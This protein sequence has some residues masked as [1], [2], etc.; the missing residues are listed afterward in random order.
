M[1]PIMMIE[2]TQAPWSGA[3]AM[4][5]D[6]KARPPDAQ[7]QPATH[8]CESTMGVI[9]SRGPGGKGL[10][11][12]DRI[13]KQSVFIEPHELLDIGSTIINEANLQDGPQHP[14]ARKPE[15]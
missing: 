10:V 9:I 1:A 2:A 15:R 8:T 3:L 12:R 14:H 5:T 11:L 13:T 7:T 4:C 6:A